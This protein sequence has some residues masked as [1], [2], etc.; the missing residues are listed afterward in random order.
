MND[1]KISINNLLVID[2]LD[3]HDGKL[4]EIKCDYINH[5]VWIPIELDS[6]KKRK[7]KA[8]MK[9]SHVKRF[10]MEIFEPWGAG[11]YVSQV[12]YNS[13]KEV[14]NDICFEVTILLNS[15]DVLKIVSE[16][17]EYSE[18]V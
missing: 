17:I 7:I 15:G 5:E 13:F 2:E 11:I 10:L 3:V 6:S 4:G 18:V 1:M 16:Q 14:D 9:F 12:K 8:V